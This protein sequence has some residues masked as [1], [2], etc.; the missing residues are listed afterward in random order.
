MSGR[1][2]C[3]QT[4]ERNVKERIS[5]GHMRKLRKDKRK[6]VV[7]RTVISLQLFCLRMPK[8]ARQNRSVHHFLH[9][10]LPV[11]IYHQDWVRS[12]VYHWW[13]TPQQYRVMSLNTC[14]RKVYSQSGLRNGSVYVIRKIGLSSLLMS[15]FLWLYYDHTKIGMHPRIT[16]LYFDVRRLWIMKLHF[17]T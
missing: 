2:S 13:R 17:T 8:N 11:L 12:A 4:R 5:I 7:T 6:L 3:L 10:G 14:S 9:Y 16:M 15:Q 1:M